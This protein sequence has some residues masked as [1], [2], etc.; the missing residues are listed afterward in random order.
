MVSAGHPYKEQTVHLLNEFYEGLLH[1]HR[2]L[3]T[4]LRIIERSV[5]GRSP[6][7][8]LTSMNKLPVLSANFRP[9]SSDTVLLNSCMW[10]VS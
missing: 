9:S 1:V 8:C 6:S 10:R 2:S 5:F 4:C 3:R 7:C